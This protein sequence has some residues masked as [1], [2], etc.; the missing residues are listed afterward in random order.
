MAYSL[1]I[2]PFSYPN[3]AIV[4]GFCIG[5]YVTKTDLIHYQ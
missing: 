4:P 2:G 3:P 1:E 5:G